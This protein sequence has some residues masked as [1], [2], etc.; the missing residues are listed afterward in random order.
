MTSTCRHVSLVLLKRVFSMTSVFSFQ[1]SVSLWP[2]LCCTPRPNLPV[3]SGSSWL[4]PFAFQSLIMRAHLLWVLVLESLEGF[5]RT[6]WL[7]LLQHYWSGHRLGLLWYWYFPWKWT[8]IIL[9]FL[10]LH[11]S[12]KFGTL[13]LTIMATSLFLRDSCPQY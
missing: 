3:S 4:P 13:S 7:Q 12:T 6:I 2:A 5:L 8:E 10:R 9:L 11:L 1:N